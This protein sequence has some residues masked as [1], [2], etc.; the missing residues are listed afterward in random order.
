MN[1][2]RTVTAPLVVMRNAVP[3]EYGAASPVV[4][5]RLPSRAW[6]SARGLDPSR[7]VNECSQATTAPPCVTVK[8]VPLFNGPPDAVVP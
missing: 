2:W 5:Y 1:S 3:P 4:P 8:A 7:S 6:M